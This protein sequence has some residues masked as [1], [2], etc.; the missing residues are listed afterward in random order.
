MQRRRREK[1]KQEIL[2]RNRNFRD[3]KLA[4]VEEVRRQKDTMKHNLYG[5]REE[6]FN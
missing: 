2:F 6:N 1:E 5:M 3:Q 4:V